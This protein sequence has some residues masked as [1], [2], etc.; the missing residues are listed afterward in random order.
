[1][2]VAIILSIATISGV[3]VMP[4][5]PNTAVDVKAAT[6]PKYNGK[7]YVSQNGNKP[8]KR[9]DRYD[10]TNWMAYSEI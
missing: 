9:C 10:Q 6:I 8:K 2:M 7:I 4:S 3:Q 1:M 5:Q